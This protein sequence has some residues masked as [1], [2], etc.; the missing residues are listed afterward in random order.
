MNKTIPILWTYTTVTCASFFL[1]ITINSCDQ[2]NNQQHSVVYTDSRTGN[3][4]NSSNVKY[5]ILENTPAQA[6]VLIR[7]PIYQTIDTSKLSTIA[8]SLFNTKSPN[9]ENPDCWYRVWFYYRGDWKGNVYYAGKFW[10][11]D[12]KTQSLIPENLDVTGITGDERQDAI[13]HDKSVAPIVTTFDTLSYIKRISKLTKAE[14]RTLKNRQLNKDG[15]VR[16]FIEKCEHLRD[17]AGIVTNEP[18]NYT[19]LFYGKFINAW[20]NINYPI[21]KNNYTYSSSVTFEA[22]YDLYGNEIYFSS[23][24]NK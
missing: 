20:G 16:V 18:G 23:S 3:K 7:E 8:D 14:L 1:M 22:T 19:H 9:I 21:T 5:E 17:S 11:H 2:T 6:V 13:N 24:L 10:R 15:E 4:N 12:Y